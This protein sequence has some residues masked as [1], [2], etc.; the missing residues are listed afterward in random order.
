MFN[1]R[2]KIKNER[3][4]EFN[5]DMKIFMSVLN[6]LSKRSKNGL[7]DDTALTD[8][9]LSHDLDKKIVVH[10]HVD[11]T[12]TVYYSYKRKIRWDKKLS[13][14]GYTC[15]AYRSYK[16]FGTCIV[17]SPLD[18]KKPSFVVTDGCYVFD[19]DLAR[20]GGDDRVVV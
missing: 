8:I 1:M 13:S 20:I 14:F 4:Y 12:G 17:V 6:E 2:K 19:I 9:P 10:Y 3:S 15:T 7:I 11:G 18:D 16:N 5:W